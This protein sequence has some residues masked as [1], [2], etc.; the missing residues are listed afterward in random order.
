MKRTNLLQILLFSVIL[1]CGTACSDE[2]HF[3]PFK[4]TMMA[5]EESTLEIP[6]TR[7]NWYISSVTSLTGSFVGDMND[8]PLQL[9]GMGT[10]N[11]RWGSIT[12]EKE[13]ALTVHLED[14]LDGEERGLIIT[15]TSKLGMYSEELI[16][17]QKA[18]DGYRLKSIVY[19]VESD[20]GKRE[21]QPRPFGIVYN[22]RTGSEQT[23]IWPYY[24]MP[25]EYQFISFDYSAFQWMTEEVWVDFPSNIVN[26]EIEFGEKCRFTRYLQ[27]IDSELKEKS[28]EVKIAPFK[29]TYIS[30]NV[31]YMHLQ[32][33]YTMTLTNINN[34]REKVIK[35]KLLKDYPFNCTISTETNELPEE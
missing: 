34:N 23:S 1:L 17:R 11:L 19:S 7:S 6:M 5:G 30:A 16:I 20:D 26:G 29:Q 33:S 27:R 2:E 24:N 21:M 31:R 12:R 13:N 8:G 14:N 28:F 4:E 22:N 10:I 15:L 35:G 32:V 18:C 25:I 9:E 3:S